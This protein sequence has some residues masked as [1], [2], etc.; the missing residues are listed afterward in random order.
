VAA[1][2]CTVYDYGSG[3]LYRSSVLD[4][5]PFGYWRLGEASGNAVDLG[6]GAGD[7]GYDV[8]AKRAQP[9][10]LAS[11][12]DG[13]VELTTTTGVRPPEGIVPRIGKQATMEA[14]FKT[15]STAAGTVIS[16]RTV[17]GGTKEEVFAVGTDGKLRS[18]YQPTTTPITTAAPVNDGAWHHAVLT[19]AD[20]LQTLYLDGAVIGTLTQPITGTENRYI[21]TIGGI[22]GLV[23]EVAIYDQGDAAVRAGARGQHLRRQDRPHRHAHRRRRRHLEDRHRRDRAAVRRSRGDGDRPGQRHTGLPV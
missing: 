1:P 16:L 9:G 7:A 22:A 10:A 15:S 11:T 17:Q 14:W 23:D 21:T 4:S 3:S 5:D 2:N 6:W 20:N 8:A 18:S 13:A 12:T 19:V